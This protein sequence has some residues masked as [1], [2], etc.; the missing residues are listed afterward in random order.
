MRRYTG[1]KN[2]PVDGSNSVDP[3]LG[4]ASSHAS[5]GLMQ[6]LFIIA[7]LLLLVKDNNTCDSRTLNHMCCCPDQLSLVPLV[8]RVEQ[9]SLLAC[10]VGPLFYKPCERFLY[11][12]DILISK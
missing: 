7:A 4:T 12:F 11:A 3:A 2:H 8:L 5:I 1:Q 10:D 9:L 6:C